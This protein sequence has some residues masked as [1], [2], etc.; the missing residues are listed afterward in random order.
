MKVFVT[1][2][3]GLLG[4]NVLRALVEAG[5]DVVGLTRSAEK[6]DWMMSDTGASFVT[7]DM[8]AVDDFAAALDGCD[9]VVHTAA[10]FREYFTPG[11]HAE[12][13]NAINVEGT[14]ALMA[15]ADKRGAKRFI[16]VSSAGVI[17]HKPDGSAGDE[18]TPPNPEMMENGYVRSK[19]AGDQKIAAF[20]PSKGMRIIEILPGWMWG[21]GD[22]APTN[23]GRL[24]KQFLAGKL[25]AVPCGGATIVDARDVAAGI[26][27][28]LS[29][30]GSGDRFIIGGEFR[31][32]RELGDLLAKYGGRKAP[33]QVPVGAAYLVAHM[34]ELAAKLSGGAPT[35]PLQGIRLIT[36]EHRVSS[37][38]AQAELGVRF[39][40]FDETI[41]AVFKWYAEHGTYETPEKTPSQAAA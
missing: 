23:A 34:S 12:A 30:E 32:T 14:L 35:V 2:S 17:G 1:G 41:G 16:H 39:R 24:V 31:T 40:P 21:P 10:Y 27:N 33:R 8:R 4:N 38:R 22:A 13:L 18:D 5:H 36:S 26:V 29:Y 7:G 37:A 11:D 9:A 28:A 19:V 15:E 20:T 25:G 3:T 6:A